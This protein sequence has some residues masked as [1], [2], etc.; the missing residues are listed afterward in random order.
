MKFKL[1]EDIYEGEKPKFFTDGIKTIKLKPGDEI[2]LNFYPGRTINSNPW[3]K[4]LTAETDER[5]KANG[6]ATKETRLRNN[7]YNAWNKGL[8]KET[9]DRVAKNIANMKSTIKDKYGVDNISQYIA[10]QPGYT[11]WNKGLTKETDD[12]MKQAS[13]N[14]KGVTAWNKGLS[15]QGHPQSEETKEKI[16][17]THLNPNF[18]HQRYEIMKA[19]G[20]LFAKDSQA[21]RDYYSKLKLEY[22]EDNIIRQYFDKDRYPFKCD[23]YIPSEDLFIEVHANWTHGGRPYNPND[24][25]CQKQLAIWQEK[26]TKSN[27]YKNAIY[28][29]TDLDVRKAE[30]AKKN[31]LNFKT[32]YYK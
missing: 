29:W 27:Y 10:S 22:A 5:V 13:D 11:V 6:Q 4:G 28:Q 7:N 2:P 20:T 24:P 3:N 19:N 14:H 9:D 15:I 32:I 26:A 31:N 21:E 12:R 1:I 23:F 16:R 18:K 8:T 30:I 17:Q 25:E